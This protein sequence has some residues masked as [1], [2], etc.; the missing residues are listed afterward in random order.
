MNT[1]RPDPP[2]PKTL[3]KLIYQMLSRQNRIMIG[4]VFPKLE[5]H[6]ERL[7]QL[8]DAMKQLIDARLDVSQPDAPVQPPT[9]HG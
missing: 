1:A 2:I 8:E 5:D 3:Q 9:I 7:A 4:E 6:D